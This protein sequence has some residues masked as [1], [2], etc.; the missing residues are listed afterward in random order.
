MYTKMQ[1]IT[2]IKKREIYKSFSLFLSIAIFRNIYRTENNTVI[3]E[4]TDCFIII[5]NW[6]SSCKILLISQIV[7]RKKLDKNLTKNN[8]YCIINSIVLT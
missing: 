7:E 4:N 8:M 3:A 5:M 1:R 2:S 6:I